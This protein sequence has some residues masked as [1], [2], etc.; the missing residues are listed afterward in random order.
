ML[1]SRWRTHLP[2][3]T[4]VAIAAAFV[5]VGQLVTWGR[6]ENP[7]AFQGPRPTNAIL[8]LLLMSAWAWRRRAPLAAVCWA[9]AVYFLSQPVIPHD[10]TFLA[11]GVPLILLTASAGYFSPRPRAVAAA[12]VALVG[13]V[14]VTLTTPYLRSADALAV[15]TVFILVP[16]VGARAL[17]QRE[18]R[19]ATL[20]A[21]LVTERATKNVALR[22]AAAAERIRI[23]RELHDIVAH[24]VSTMVIQIG[25]A[26]MQLRTEPTSPEQPLLDAEAVG[27]QA[28]EDL[29]RLLSVLRADQ[30]ADDSSATG[31]EPPLPGLS[32]VDT[33]V[34]PVRAAG[35]HV[36]VEVR[37]DPVPLPAML[38]LASYRILQEALT[39]TLKHGRATRATVRLSYSPSALVIDVV[40]DGTAAPA[41]DPAGH[42]LLGIR[43]RVSL[44]GGTITAGP[45]GD[46]GWSVHAELPLA[47]V[48]DRSAV[49]L[50]TS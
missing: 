3:V 25:A 4:D 5:V 38:D 10:M 18:D 30:G 9:V 50:P 34:G 16:W 1:A 36:D 49:A 35:L 39:N 40:D 12:A 24:S 44:F 26:R 8:S 11:G 32:Q 7:A 47:S 48:Q 22:E 13:L 41:A 28:L 31:P 43:E 37:G 21:A 14:V 27:R 42:G 20:A 15:N 45:L 6:F 33:I 23:A 29:R 19:A 46:G 17:R 2:P